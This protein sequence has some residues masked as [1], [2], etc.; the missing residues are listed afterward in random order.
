MQFRNFFN[1][2]Y[3]ITGQSV[4]YDLWRIF[5]G[6]VYDL[7]RGTYRKL[8]IFVFWFHM[9]WIALMLGGIG[10]AAAWDWY[11]PIHKV[12]M[13]ATIGSQI[14]W[15]GC[16]LTTLEMIF[17]KKADPRATNYKGSFTAF[18]L[19]K[20]FGIEISQYAVLITLA[21]AVTISIYVI[22]F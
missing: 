11:K 16:P 1:L 15:L 4:L 18:L 10:M 14:L 22:Y 21:I 19:R 17:K 6:D 3:E 8:S 2:A 9:F 20:I 5:G 13:I 12:V 7:S